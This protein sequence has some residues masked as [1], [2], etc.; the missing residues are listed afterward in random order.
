MNKLFLICFFCFGVTALKAQKI[1]SV[2][3]KTKDNVLDQKVFTWVE[4]MPD[5]PG[6]LNAY[7][8]FL[9][10]N[11]VYPESARQRGVKGFVR[12]SF[13]VEMDGNL[14]DFKVLKSLSKEMD[15]EAVRVLR[16]SPKWIAG[17]QNG[18]PR[19]VAMTLIVG[20][21]PESLAVPKDTSV[22]YIKMVG[23]EETLVDSK[24]KA[25]FYRVVLP[26]DTTVD[27]TL[28]VINE[29]YRSGRKKMIGNATIIDRQ[30]LL[31]GS[32]M[33]FYENGKRKSIK[34]Y[35]DGVQTGDYSQYYPSGKL[36]ITGE[37]SPD[38]SKKIKDARDTTGK[39]IASDGIGNM[40]IYSN[41]FKRI[42]EEG[43]IVNS[44]EEG[45]WHG[46]SADSARSI[47]NYKHGLFQNG[48]SFDQKGLAY[49]DKQPFPVPAYPGGKDA[50]WTFLQ[51][52]IRYPSV[53]KEAHVQGQVYV[54][55]NVER[56]GS[57]TNV[58]VVRGAGSGL[59][60]EA[61]RVIKLSSKWNPGMLG[62]IPVRTQYTLPI[63]FSL[64]VEN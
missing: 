31:S 22:F 11:L 10:S 64:Q 37:C 14:S 58:H 7:K 42:V 13:I 28:A 1:D 38:G 33:E 40:I 47:I 8:R 2:G 17:T 48:K 55:F 20:F 53:A 49:P 25:D 15:A 41:D 44:V 3:T 63:S 45:E 43:P 4:K 36:Y 6:G 52:T 21:P 27:K 46:M 54:S 60:E 30:L 35:V 9:A 59:D 16:N 56:D 34:N 18:S 23:N 29:F 61:I 19:R 5:F 50:L 62:G 32:C 39:I 24:D 26:P 51:N 12:V 57:L